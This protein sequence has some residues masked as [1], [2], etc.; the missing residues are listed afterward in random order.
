[1]IFD[2]IGTPTKEEIKAVENEKWRDFCRKAKKRSGKDFKRMFPDANPLAVDLLEK[3]LVF[4]P[5]KR[6]SVGQALKHEYLKGLHIEE[7][8][9]TREPINPL[10]FEFEKHR[11]NGEQLKGM[12]TFG[13]L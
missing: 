7:D 13:A 5:K 12:W 6:L 11:L 3:L 10:E 1:M 4:D 8:E 9:P 2:L